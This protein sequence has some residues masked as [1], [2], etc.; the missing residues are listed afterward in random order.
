MLNNL[1]FSKIRTEGKH[2]TFPDAVYKAILM[3]LHEWVRSIKLTMFFLKDFS[4]KQQ[5]YP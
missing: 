5:S 4:L 2:L 3:C 1:I